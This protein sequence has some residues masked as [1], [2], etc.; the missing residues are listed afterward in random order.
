[1]PRRSLVLSPLRVLLIVRWISLRQGRAPVSRPSGVLPEGGFAPAGSGT[2]FRSSEVRRRDVVEV[3]W[4]VLQ[5]ES[6]S[7]W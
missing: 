1:M 4:E 7:L 5:K 3:A 2:S 6:P